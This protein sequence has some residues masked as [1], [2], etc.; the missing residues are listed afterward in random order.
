MKP[1]FELR[2]YDFKLHACS[3]YATLPPKKSRESKASR[4]L[5]THVNIS[6]SFLCHAIFGNWNLAPPWSPV[7]H[8]LIKGLGILWIWITIQIGLL[9]YVTWNRLLTLSESVFFPRK[10]GNDHSYLTGMSWI[11]NTLV[12]A[13]FFSWQAHSRSLINA[14]SVCHLCCKDY[15]IIQ[16]WNYFLTSLSHRSLFYTPLQGYCGY[17]VF[18]FPN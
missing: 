14:V 1:R 16:N 9:H 13:V 5:G 6:A 11:I 2:W 3:F 4:W 18:H 8:G 17:L 10:T 15:S 7:L 12:Y